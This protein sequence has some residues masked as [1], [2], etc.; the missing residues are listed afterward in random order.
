MSA[1]DAGARMVPFHCPYCSDEDL[2]PIEG[3][4]KE[5]GSAW[6][7]RPCAPTFALKFLG[8]RSSGVS[9]T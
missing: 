5:A 8:L 3:G 9:T 2:R 7:C 4:T 1:D 6:E